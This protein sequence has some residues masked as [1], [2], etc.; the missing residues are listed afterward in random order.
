MNASFP[1]TGLSA[2]KPV[3]RINPRRQG[4]DALARQRQHQPS[5]VAL[6]L[7]VAAR[8]PKPRGQIVHVVD[9]PFARSHRCLFE[10]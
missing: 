9:E 4:L 7:G 5:A 6:E 2:M 8:M 10:R 3:H 1:P